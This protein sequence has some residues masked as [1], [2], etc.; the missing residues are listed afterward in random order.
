MH[1]LSAVGS[2]VYSVS[3]A[4]DGGGRLDPLVSTC[5]SC[6]A[7][8]RVDHRRG[9]LLGDVPVQAVLVRP[10]DHDQQLSSALCRRELDSL[11]R[12]DVGL[13]EGSTSWGG[14]G[15]RGEGRVLVAQSQLRRGIGG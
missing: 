10:L 9:L 2:T 15:L 5:I 7:V 4:T 3:M 12:Y 13:M 11:L 8:S 1:R 6:V 14:G